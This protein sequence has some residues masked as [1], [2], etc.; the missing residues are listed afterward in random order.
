MIV[1]SN[2]VKDFFKKTSQQEKITSLLTTFG[3][4]VPEGT[5][6]CIILDNLQS[7]DDLLVQPWLDGLENTR[8]AIS[9]L[10]AQDNSHFWERAEL[11]A[12]PLPTYSLDY[13]D[14]RQAV[15]FVSGRLTRFRC[16]AN[17]PW[18]LKEEFK[19]FPFKETEI[20]N[21]VYFN[22]LTGGYTRMGNSKASIRNL[23]TVLAG[24]LDQ[25]L[26]SRQHNIDVRKMTPDE[27][28]GLFMDLNGHLRTIWNRPR[29]A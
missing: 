28:K 11:Q 24:A 23:N 27:V 19:L 16:K 12:S 6:G 8:V 1:D 7:D 13:L 21:A 5:Y 18:L 3:E 9:F 15:E 22:L 20:S 10:V 14:D 4:K 26:S 25:E 17:V 29:A 2:A